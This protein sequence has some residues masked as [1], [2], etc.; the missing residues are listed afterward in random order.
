MTFEPHPREFFT[1]GKTSL[2]ISSL[3]VKL[4]AMAELGVNCVFMMRFNHKLASLSGDDFIKNILVDKLKASYVI[5]GENFHFG[6]DRKGDKNILSAAAEKYGFKYLACPPI[7]NPH[8]NTISSSTIRFLLGEGNMPEAA[9]LLGHPY[10]IE[11]RVKHGEGRGKMLGFPT[12]NI[13][14][15]KLFLPRLGIYAVRVSISPSPSQG[16]GRGEGDLAN[17][18][19]PHP[20]PLPK[21]ERGV[22]FGVASIGTKP[23]FGIYAPLLEVHLFDTNADLYGKRICVEFVEFIR[24]EEKFAGVDELKNQI[25]ADC[26]R[27]KKILGNK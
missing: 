21:R 14:L 3:R 27:A 4:A 6:K 16:E 13:E 26:E 5:T 8:G 18:K 23:T 15:G 7:T 19:N 9:K 17:T 24:A 22:F 20:S 25:A 12:A 11:G 10:R 1:R 2:R